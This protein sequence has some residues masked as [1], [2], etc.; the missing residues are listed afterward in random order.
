VVPVKSS[1]TKTT[2]RLSYFGP[3]EWTRLDTT[4]GCEEEGGG[5]NSNDEQPIKLRPYYVTILEVDHVPVRECTGRGMKSEKDI[6]LKN[7]TPSLRR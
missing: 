1:S 7:K 5:C 3:T 6:M 4:H 2:R